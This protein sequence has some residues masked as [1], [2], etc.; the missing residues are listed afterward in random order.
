[1][2]KDRLTKIRQHMKAENIDA[3]LILS[4][5]YH[6]SE[7]MSDF[8]K[9]RE[10]ISGFTGSA[11]DVV[12][13]PT[14]SGLWTDGRYFLQ[15]ERELSNSGIDL[16]RIGEDGVEEIEQY[17]FKHLH[18]GAVLGVDGKTI[19]VE[20]YLKLKKLL[21]KK[22][23]S[24]R[25]DCD[26]VGDIWENR[27]SIPCQ[28]VW[29]LGLEY[30]GKSRKEKLE[31]VR[32][33][34]RE[35]GNDMTFISSLEDIAWVLN[36]RGSDIACTPVALSY[37]AVHK[38]Y[39]VWF[40]Q[41]DAVDP[42]L[43]QKLESDGVQIRDY[44]DADHFFSESFSG[45]KLY[46]D[47]NKTNTVIYKNAKKVMQVEKGRNLTM[48]PKAI[49]NQVEIKNEQKAH[50]KDAIAC[51]KFIYWLKTHVSNES[52]TEISA[53][54]K[55]EEYRKEQENYIEPSFDTIVGYAQHG[56]VVHYSATPETNVLL[57]P[58]NFVLIDS[59]GQYLEGTTDITRTIALGQLTYEQKLYYTLVLK[60]HIRLANVKFKYGCSG[61]NLDCLAREALWEQGLDYKHG[62]GHGVGYLLGVHEP[63]NSFRSQ[64]SE[65]M[66]ECTKLEAG[67]ITSNE[68][69]VYLSGE[70]GIRIENL[71][72]CKEI[73]KTE[74]GKF[75]GFDMLTLVPY[76][77]DAILVEKLTDVEKNWIN[78][79]HSTVY[80][81]IEPYLDQEE[82]VWLKAATMEL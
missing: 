8:F 38:E 66:D 77:K 54:E 71:M 33:Q 28:P 2:I 23:I 17:L 60:G 70:Y 9:C 52:I 73:E 69:G 22:Q 48:L 79:Y 14:E 75:M 43:K 56:A 6:G 74:Y 72:I 76:E 19:C 25:I 61:V 31:D 55:L 11:G 50:R 10:F 36:I 16:H 30:A 37:L 49:K 65:S 44:G 80:K 67:M 24:I 53:A 29:E 42:L 82:K 58:E 39:A 13:L 40:V 20:K 68:P 45:Q 34:L 41:L 3:Y 35:N 18:E 64:V 78:Q 1:M 47:F 46:L 32:N 59:G 81:T 7:Y 21:E 57:K 51:I 62:T 27:P 63:P 4:S 5:D 26:L 15:A 12:I